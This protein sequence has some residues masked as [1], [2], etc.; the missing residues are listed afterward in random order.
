MLVR[1]LGGRHTRQGGGMEGGG[2]MRDDKTPPRALLEA[3]SKR[4]NGGTRGAGEPADSGVHDG[5]NGEKHLSQRGGDT[6]KTC[7]V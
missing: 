4:S 2:R 7:G 1:L 5:G 6:L 3:Q